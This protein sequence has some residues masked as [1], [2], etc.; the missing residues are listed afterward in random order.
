MDRYRVF[1]QCQAIKSLSR[2][3]VSGVTV[4]PSSSST[5]SN[6]STLGGSGSSSL[7]LSL[8]GGANKAVNEEGK[9]GESAFA[10]SSSMKFP[11][12]SSKIQ[13][14][15]LSDCLL[16][17]TSTSGMMEGS[18]VGGGDSRSSSAPAN[19]F[20]RA[21]SAF[22]IARWQNIHS[23]ENVNPEPIENH[24]IGM[25]ALLEAL[26]DLYID[27]ETQMPFSMNFQ[28]ESS[29]YLRNCLL[30]AI[31]SIR[32]QNGK[33]PWEIIQTLLLFMEDLDQFECCNE[34]NSTGNCPSISPLSLNISVPL[35]PFL[36]L[37]LPL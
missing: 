9:T 21:E 7:S 30:L 6:N 12:K 19:I 8:G 24:W 2:S 34:G 18:H 14:K 11:E 4:N 20:V 33:T 22:G 35:P 23:S 13:I 29:V 16:G 1:Y 5:S 31:S 37:P 32:S 17:I 10:S 3:I 15:A 25:E 27:P 28:N 26:Y 36:F